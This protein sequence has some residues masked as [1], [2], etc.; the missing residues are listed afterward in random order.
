MFNDRLN[1][2]RQ[3]IAKLDLEHEAINIASAAQRASTE[4]VVK[5]D[6]GKAKLLSCGATFA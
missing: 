4:F 5:V 6:E 2:Y 3:R 1:A